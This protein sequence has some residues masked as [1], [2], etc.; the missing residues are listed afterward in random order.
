MV[1]ADDST[2][3]AEIVGDEDAQTPFELL[4]DKN[5]RDEV[6]DL[7][8]VLDDRERKIIFQRFARDGGKPKTLEE[9][10]KKFGLTRERIRQ[11][12]NI[13]TAAREKA[14]MTRLMLAALS[15]SI[16]P[17]AAICSTVIYPTVLEWRYFWLAVCVAG[18]VAMFVFLWKAC[19]LFYGTNKPGSR[20]PSSTQKSKSELTDFANDHSN[21]LYTSQVTN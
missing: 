6:S 1:L 20:G 9:V 12:Q 5:L 18:F 11:L 7:L 3:F 21:Y 4:I 10:G 14:V 13:D 15:G 8:E 17:F 16:S 19:E 2:E